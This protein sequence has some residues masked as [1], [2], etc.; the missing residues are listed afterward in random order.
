MLQVFLEQGVISS[1]DWFVQHA[2]GVQPGVMRGERRLDVDHIA[3]RRRFQRG[4]KPRADS[5]VQRGVFDEVLF[6]G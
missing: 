3:V 1:D 4:A 6:G 2:G 5:F